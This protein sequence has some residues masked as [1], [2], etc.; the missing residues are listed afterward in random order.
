MIDEAKAN[1]NDLIANAPTLTVDTDAINALFSYE[2]NTYS[3]AD[4]DYFG[5]LDFN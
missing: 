2:A 1:I 4:T 3:F 5:R